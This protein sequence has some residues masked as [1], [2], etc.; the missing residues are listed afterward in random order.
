MTALI[1]CGLLAGKDA[2]TIKPQ[3]FP[4]TKIIWN[5]SGSATVGGS[6]HDTKFDMIEA[7]IGDPGA[8]GQAV[9][10]NMDNLIV[11]G[12]PLDGME[13]NGTVSSVNLVSA[14]PDNI[15]L[16][17]MFSIFDFVYP[18]TPVSVGD[19]WPSD[20]AFVDS[21]SGAK[22]TRHTT[23]SYTVTK[24]EAVDGSDALV[25]DATVKE[26]GDSGLNAT[27]TWWLDKTGKLL[28]FKI[29]AKNWTVVA[30]GTTLTGSCSFTGKLKS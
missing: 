22:Q 14:S 2:W 21:S 1:I 26:D 27:E 10:V 15:D 28:K 29:E 23:G 3:L 17:R 9:K 6:D 24:I 30:Q 16:L 12:S 7:A 4:R 13:L 19:K 8:K 18:S 20:V 11:D 5:V 25:V